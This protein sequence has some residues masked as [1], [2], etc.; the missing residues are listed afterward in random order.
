MEEKEMEKSYTSIFGSAKPGDTAKRE[1]EIEERLLKKQE[2]AQKEP[3]PAKSDSDATGT[4]L[5]EQTGKNME[6]R[7]KAS[8]P[9]SE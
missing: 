3:D 8:Y 4:P 2:K 7:R 5:E 1:W 6:R 9:D